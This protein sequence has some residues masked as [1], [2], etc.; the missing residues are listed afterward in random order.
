M[1]LHLLIFYCTYIHKCNKL[2]HN[3]R[4]FHVKRIK[5]T[6]DTH[7]SNRWNMRPC[8][9]NVNKRLVD[10]LICITAVFPEKRQ[11]L[12]RKERGNI[13][14]YCQHICGIIYDQLL[15]KCQF[16][17]SLNQYQG[18]WMVNK[19][20]IRSSWNFRYELFCNKLS[21]GKEKTCIF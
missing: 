8:H 15:N 1:W 4:V 19:L 13:L 16:K 18:G 7:V 20:T 5:Y 3:F 14:I 12:I 17:R 9:S 11:T 21:F 2:Y 10:F 6:D